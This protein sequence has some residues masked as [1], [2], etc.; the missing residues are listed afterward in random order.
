VVHSAVTS[1]LLPSS[2]R[3]YCS[4][5]LL[6]FF[7]AN[8]GRFSRPL[9]LHGAYEFVPLCPS[10]AVGHSCS[11]SVFLSKP[12]PV[13]LP[14]STGLSVHF[15]FLVRCCCRSLLWRL[16]PMMAAVVAGDTGLSVLASLVCRF[17]LPLLSVVVVETHSC[18]LCR[19]RP[20]FRFSVL[21]Y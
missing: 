19:Y 14:V 15:G 12:A 1:P 21:L 13:V 17:S 9:D 11:M 16:T 7:H 8:H 10:I 6:C 20:D 4:Y 2:C 5:L 18:C 3:C